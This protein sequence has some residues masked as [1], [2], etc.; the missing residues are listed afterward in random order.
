[1]MKKLM[2]TLMLAAVAVN[3]N[4][5]EVKQLPQPDMQLSV[6]LTEALQKRRSDREYNADR[7]ITDQQ[8]S[9]ILWAACGV[10][11]PDKKLLTIPTAINAQDI[12]VY[13]CRKDGVALYQPYDNTLKKVSSEDIR[14]LLAERQQNMKNAP[15][16]LLIVSDQEKFRHNAEVYGAM[17]AGYASQDICLMCAALGLKAVPRAMMNKEAVAKAL[18]LGE[19]QILELNHPIGY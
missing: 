19:K 7:D 4:A 10:N 11:R 1:M 18:G 2:F 16:F 14:P 3:M 13:V 5:Q 9:Q 8:L 12:Q 17:D 6:T 15:V